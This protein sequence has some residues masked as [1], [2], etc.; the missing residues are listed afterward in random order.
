M[1]TSVLSVCLSCKVVV[2][3]FSQHPFAKPASFLHKCLCFLDNM[4]KIVKKKQ[5]GSEQFQYKLMI[6]WL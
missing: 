3:Q 6:V 5:L 4:E 1:E 2:P